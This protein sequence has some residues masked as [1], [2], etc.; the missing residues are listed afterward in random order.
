MTG[1]YSIAYRTIG[2]GSCNANHACYYYG[3]ADS[4]VKIGSGSCNVGYVCEGCEDGSVVLDGTCN[5]LLNLDEVV[6]GIWGTFRL[7]K[8]TQTRIK[9]S[10]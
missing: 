9:S 5:D 7:D 10:T 4:S 2:D 6:G 1:S 8:S 3:D